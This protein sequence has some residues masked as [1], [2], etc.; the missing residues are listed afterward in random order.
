MTLTPTL[1]LILDGFGLGP[2]GPGNAIALA[3]T[4]NLDKLF[5]TCSHTSLGASGRDV[6]LPTGYI[7]NSEVGH[8]NIGAGRVAY[9]DMTRIDMAGESGELDKNAVFLRLLEDIQ[10]KNGRLHLLG[11]LS[12][13]GVHSHIGHVKALA[14][15]AHAKGVE[16]LVHACTDGRDVPP[17]SGEEF[18]ADLHNYLQ[19]LGACR[20]A[21]VC[22]RFF[23]MDRDKR[24]ERVH[25]AYE[26]YVHGK[27]NVV[28]DAVSGFKAAYAASESDEFIKPMLVRASPD[29]PNTLRDNDGI[30]FFN[31][32]AD[33][34]REIV[35][36]F[37]PGFTEFDCGVP[38]R[39]SGMASMTAYDASFPLPVA[40]PKEALHM[41]LGEVAAQMGKKQLRLAE[42]EKYAHVTY[43]FN[44]GV[45][46]PLPGEDR[47]L[48]P[49]PREVET[50]DLKPAMSAEEVTE[51]FLEAWK[52]GA[53][54][55][56]VCNLANP[57]MVGH[58]GVLPAAV[59]ACET[60]D[61]CVGRMV[62][63][64][65]ASG[66]RV[67][68]TADHGNAECMLD[69]HNAPHTAHTMNPTPFILV[70]PDGATPKPYEGR[71][72][73]IAPTILSLWNVSQPP[74]MTG[75]PLTR[76]QK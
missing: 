73:D 58:T 39:L 75:R 3:K 46:E 67:C 44:G 74:E 41:G 63:A 35:R 38:P 69:D 64:V 34:M 30:F 4:P 25:E 43:F 22:G 7:G 53:Y 45:E 72:A 13:G 59:A 70:E 23:A 15:I 27:G 26:L 60:V 14:R 50:Y 47:T 28:D 76:E 11:L 65:T 61:A 2:K 8:L 17:G 31:F 57:D 66:G 49:S 62:E 16:T 68:I 55:L 1:L 32:R 37:L 20:I 42:T 33:R 12:D 54:T 19:G 9:Q 40:F 48:V 21:S 5:L 51:R 71:L 6:G 10:G 18:L 56:V 29:A 24:W 52:S 36:A